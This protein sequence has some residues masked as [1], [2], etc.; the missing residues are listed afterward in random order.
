MFVA[1]PLKKKN[2][3]AIGSNTA[4]GAFKFWIN[5]AQG[6]S[7]NVECYLSSRKIYAY[8]SDNATSFFIQLKNKFKHPIEAN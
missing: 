5:P 7:Y 6:N 1:S 2:S 8:F 4:L 3:E